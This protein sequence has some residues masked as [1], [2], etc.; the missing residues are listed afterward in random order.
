MTSKEYDKQLSNQDH[1][2][3]YAILKFQMNLT[4]PK[5]ISVVRTLISI[6]FTSSADW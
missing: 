3:G 1:N 5:A 2:F 4:L 6:L